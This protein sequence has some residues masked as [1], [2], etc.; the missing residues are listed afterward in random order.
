VKRL[1][2][3]IIMLAGSTLAQDAAALLGYVT[4]QRDP[5]AGYA[6][7]GNIVA[8]F[9]C[10]LASGTGPLLNTDTNNRATWRDLSGNG[11]DIKLTSFNFT[12]T[13][14]WRTADYGLAFDGTNGVAT[15]TVASCVSNI[16]VLLV[17]ASGD[18]TI[19]RIPIFSSSDPNA[20]AGAF[21]ISVNQVSANSVLSFFKT[22]A[23]NSFDYTAINAI[24]TGAIS[25]ITMT[26]QATNTAARFEQG[27]IGTNAVMAGSSDNRALTPIYNGLLNI[28][29]YYGTSP[30]YK[31]TIYLI[32]VW[33]ATL[34]AAEVESNLGTAR[35]A[36]GF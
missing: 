29:S 15:G 22:T 36:F 26:V 9:D 3:V 28:G 14:G 23:A 19:S 12:E 2:A 16:T 10:R 18:S 31:G 34:T 32:A 21:Y 4:A 5:L 33:N 25:A 35:A 27:Y 8:F 24:A 20:N 6:Q 7:R 1:A 30:R 17:T 11:R 13:N